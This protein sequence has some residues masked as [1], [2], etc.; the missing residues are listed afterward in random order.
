[1]DV[2][3][4]HARFCLAA[5]VSTGPTG[6]AAWEALEWALRHYGFPCQVLSDN[7]TCFTGRLVHGVVDFE[8]RL[9]GLGIEL[10]T[11]RPYHPQTL[12]KL[13]RFHRTMKEWLADHAVPETMEELQLALDR[14]REHYNHDRPHQ[15]MADATPA[16]RYRAGRGPHPT[17]PE[18]GQPIYPAGAIVRRVDRAG[19]I[20]Y[21][22]AHLGVGKRWRHLMVRVVDLAGVTHIYFGEELIRSLVIDPKVSY[23][24]S[25]TTPNGARPGRGQR[26]R[27]RKRPRQV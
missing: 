3:D 18:P 23:Q 1:M 7:G 4:D 17:A 26:S 27:Q 9:E 6:E 8:R 15:A 16:E 10:I 14:F 5:R 19:V 2:I 22:G 11:S 25:T 24:R 21:R 13:E 12:G 20:G